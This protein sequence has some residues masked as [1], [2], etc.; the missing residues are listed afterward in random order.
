MGGKSHEPEPLRLPLLSDH[1]ISNSDL[2]ADHFRLEKKLGAV[3]DA[4]RLKD[5][6]TPFSIMLTGGW[7]AG[8]TS[9]MSWLDATFK[10]EKQVNSSP[11]YCNVDTCWFYPWKYQNKEDVWRGLI[12]EVILRAMRVEGVDSAKILK[13]AD[14][15][16]V[17]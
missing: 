10:S 17:V 16:S 3:V 13:A 9:A 1:A 4:I 6:A 8:K 11:N 7:G 5:T 14:R 2:E 15:K 12:A